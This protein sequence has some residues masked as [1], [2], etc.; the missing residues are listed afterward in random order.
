MESE[1]LI[2]AR[3]LARSYGRT[4]AVSGLDLTLRKGEIL[5]LLG[6]NG[7]GKSTTMKMLTGNLAPSSGEVL[8]GG[9]SLREDAKAAKRSL[10]YLPEQPPVYPELTVDEYLDYCAGLHG[11]ARRARGEAVASARRDCGL[12]EVGSRLIGNLSKGYQQRVGLAQAI[13]HRPPVIVLDEPTVGLDPIQIREIRALIATLARNHSVIL[14]SHILPEI[15]AV[16]SRVMIINR[17]RVVYSE[18]VAAAKSAGFSSI[19][20]TFR[21]LPDART[22]ETLAGVRRVLVLGEGRY[23]IECDAS[24][25]PREAIVK[26]AVEGGWGLLELRAE[27]QTLEEIFVELVLRGDAAAEK[28]VA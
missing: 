25:D 13:I 21:Q 22:L 12:T 24:A 6:P 19:A 18:P 3:A 2:E 17:G 10:G 16:C 11:I 23:R 8:I 26:A 14:S 20:A 9:K 7:A 1:V 5:G 15:Q 4:L 27:A 28:D